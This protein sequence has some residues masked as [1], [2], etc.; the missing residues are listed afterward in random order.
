MMLSFLLYAQPN[1]DSVR[2]ELYKVNQVFDSA[3]YLGFDVD[4]VSSS[5]T[6][7]GRYEHE[8]MKGNYI[9][10]NKNIYYRMGATEYA[11]NDSFLYNIY[12]DEKLLMMTRNTVS[13]NSGLFPLK[14][15]IDSVV[16]WYDSL[17]T[18]TLTSDT[19]SKI[20]QFT[21]NQSGLPYQ[22]FAIYYNEY[23]YYP[24]K[25]EMSLYEELDL[26]GVP[27]SLLQL[28]RVRPVE[29]R[30][31]MSFSNYHNPSNLG[32]FENENY[33]YFDRLRKIYLPGAKLKAYR[34]IANGVP[35][36]ENDETIE[37][38]PPPVEQ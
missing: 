21:A 26:T 1:L 14:N 33:V 35:G 32:V 18:I 4:I 24:D 16:T 13:S 2:Q 9:L 37:M 29:K 36:E 17:Y 23:S 22:R 6:L 5:D 3:R 7:F 30:I 12:H 20:I 27:D 19:N 38:Y 15:F 10:N 31:T 8:E 28:I 25:F 34:F 11:Q